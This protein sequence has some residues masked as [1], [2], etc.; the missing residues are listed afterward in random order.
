M[1]QPLLVAG[2]DPVTGWLSILIESRD[3]LS[4]HN[5]L[6]LRLLDPPAIANPATAR[7]GSLMAAFLEL[8]LSDQDEDG[9]KLNRF[10]LF[11]VLVK[12]LTKARIVEVIW[13]RCQ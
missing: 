7:G 12:R 2:W 13:P 5:V 6:V 9:D 8:W 10:C 4:R 1:R 11:S 3:L